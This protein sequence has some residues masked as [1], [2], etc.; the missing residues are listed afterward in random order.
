MAYVIEVFFLQK[1][2]SKVED[3]SYGFYL[4]QLIYDRAVTS[5]TLYDRDELHFAMDAKC[6]TEES[7][8]NNCWLPLT[9]QTW[10]VHHVSPSVIRCMFAKD[11]A[12]G[13]YL[14]AEVETRYLQGLLLEMAEYDHH[15]QSAVGKIQ[16]GQS[17]QSEHAADLCGC[18]VT[19]PAHPGQPLQ[20][21]RLNEYST[22]PRLH[23]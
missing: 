23:S 15:V 16:G 13:L 19:P 4:W 9:D 11:I 2:I 10:I 6:C 21:G 8:P 22:G 17:S 5:I 12:S 1:I 14:P 18:V 7:H 3:V 20:R